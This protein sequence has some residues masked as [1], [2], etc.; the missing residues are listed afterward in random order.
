MTTDTRFLKVFCTPSEQRTIKKQ[1]TVIEAY[2]GFIVVEV[3]VGQRN[4]LVGKYP[5]EDITDRRHVTAPGNCGSWHPTC[6]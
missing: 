4:A 1:F 5:V 3:P 2:E 6:R